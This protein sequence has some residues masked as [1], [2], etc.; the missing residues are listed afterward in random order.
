MSETRDL[1]VPVLVL[2]AAIAVAAWCASAGQGT[3]AVAAGALGLVGAGL[4]LRL[5]LRKAPLR[6]TATAVGSLLLLAALSPAFESARLAWVPWSLLAFAAALARTTWAPRTRVVLLGAAVALVAAALAVIVLRVP[7]GGLWA[8]F[9]VAGAFACALNVLVSRPRPVEAAPVGPVVGVFGGSFDPFHLGHRAIC[10]AALGVVQ[11]LLVVVSARP[12]HKRGARELSAFH[13]RVAMTRIGIEGLPRTEVLELEN[14]REGPSYTIDTLAALGR[15]FPPGS[16]FRLVLGADSFQDFPTWKD[17]EGI[18][19]KADLL[20]VGRPGHDLEPPPEFEG[21]NAPVE[22]LAVPP[23]EASSTA[24]RARVIAGEPPGPMVSAA[25]A[26]YIGDH[27]LYKD[28]TGGGEVEVAA[29][30]PPSA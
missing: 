25:V 2:L 20:V 9:A 8:A 17:W 12:P 13:H 6:A 7:G 10:E 15:L 28:G 22:R 18:L 1:G 4:A 23:N 29:A 21:R 27:G 5:T 16:R 14:R 3:W 30:R 26:A 19:E 24:V 11:R